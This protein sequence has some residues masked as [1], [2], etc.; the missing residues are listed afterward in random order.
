MWQKLR[1]LLQ[2]RTN[3]FVPLINKVIQNK[4]L[5][6]EEITFCKNWDVN[7]YGNHVQVMGVEEQRGRCYK[8]QLFIRKKF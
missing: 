8:T 1:N 6:V 3:L 5:Y 2:N 7:F 4:K